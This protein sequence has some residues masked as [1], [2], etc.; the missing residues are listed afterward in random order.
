MLESQ[1]RKVVKRL[2][3]DY[4]PVAV[5]NGIACPGTPDLECTLGWIE[6]KATNN[7]PARE[8]TVVRLD[9][10]LS[11]QQ[12]IW[13]VRRHRAG[14]RC[15]VLL[16]VGRDWLLFGPEDAARHLGKSTKAEMYKL[17]I[18]TWDTTPTS[19]Q[20]ITCLRKN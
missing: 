11:P 15:W 5:E 4:D 3:A 13:L 12:R 20:L 10:D 1:M 9:H 14:A 2:L 8:S 18:A 19:E 17:A 7:W 16:T 6:L